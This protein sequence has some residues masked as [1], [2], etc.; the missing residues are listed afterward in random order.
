MKALLKTNAYDKATDIHKASGVYGSHI[1]ALIP[2]SDKSFE[3][4]RWLHNTP[5]LPFL[6]ELRPNIGMIDKLLQAQQL[7]YW[8]RSEP[9]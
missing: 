8:N 1:I 4:M 7:R 6:L 3:S 2:G 5:D 9:I